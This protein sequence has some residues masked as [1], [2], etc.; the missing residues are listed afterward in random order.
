M[1][2][3]SSEG[4]IADVA[5]NVSLSA[6]RLTAAS[7]EAMHGQKWGVLPTNCSGRT[8]IS[9]SSHSLGQSDR[10]IAFAALVLE[11][12]SSQPQNCSVLW[13]SLIMKY[14]QNK[15]GRVSQV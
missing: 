13:P 2:P 10:L 5:S 12:G 1:R 8:S 11:K 6:F 14:E 15:S 4:T 9:F 3:F 7:S